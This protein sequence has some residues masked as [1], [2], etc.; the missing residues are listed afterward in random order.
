MK[1]LYVIVLL[2]LLAVPGIR[3]ETFSSEP[4][5]ITTGKEAKL[6]GVINQV[7]VPVP[8][9]FELGPTQSG[10]FLFTSR[11]FTVKGEDAI[12]DPVEVKEQSLFQ[13]VVPE[14]M[15]AKI[16]ALLSKP[17]EVNVSVFTAHTRYHRTPVVLEVKAIRELK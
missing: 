1:K 11:T 14:K 9:D 3:G 16:Q 12:G 17:V 13:L 5:V 7:S 10:Y 15:D 8:A 4:A 6:R 2:T